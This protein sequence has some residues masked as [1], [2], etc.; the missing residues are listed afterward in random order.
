MKLIKLIEENDIITIFRHQFADPDAMGSQM[1]LKAFIESNYPEKEVYALGDSI[2]SC[3]YMF[4]GVDHVDDEVIANSLA[5][6]CDTANADRVDDERFNTAKMVLKID[7]H[8]VVDEFAT[9]AI[10][11]TKASATC[12]IV[13]DIIKESNMNVSYECAKYL[14]FGLLAD[15][16]NFTTSNTTANTLLCASYLV[17][18]GLEVNKLLQERTNLSLNDFYY[19]SDIRSKAIVK[20][21][22][23]FSIMNKNDYEKYGF[24]YKFAKEKVFTLANINEIEIW[25]LFTQDD[26]SEEVVF[27]GSL[28]SKNYA[29]NEVAN[30]YSGGGHKNACGVKKL[31][32]EDLDQL[33]KDLNNICK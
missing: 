23:I 25:C 6:V 17:S 5:I 18:Q 27:N 19:I 16:A 1:G 10:V 2:G 32:L 8:V 4:P 11:N 3:A 13:A 9:K 21:K 28:R 31:T 33:I 22:V 15:S 14:Y 26:E 29:I 20:D 12:E 24:D 30:K 7:H